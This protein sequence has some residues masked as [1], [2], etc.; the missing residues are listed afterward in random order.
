MEEK[1]EGRKILNVKCKKEILVVCDCCTEM[2]DHMVQ[3]ISK[4]RALADESGHLVCVLYIG[5][6]R[7]NTIKEISESGADFLIYGTGS[8]YVE[9]WQ[10]SD[11]ITYFIKEKK[12]ELVLFQASNFGKDIAAIISTRFEAGLT[13][14]C[15]EILYDSE[16]GFRF[17]RAAICDSVIAQISCINCDINMG[18]VKE[19]VFE[20]SKIERKS[21]MQVLD[22]KL[23][24]YGNGYN[25]NQLCLDIQQAEQIENKININE[26]ATVF[27]IGR[28]ASSPEC[29]KAIYSLAE[30]YNACV[31][32]TR[33][34][35][36]DGIMEKERQVGQSGK[37]ISPQLYIGFG[38]FGAS[39]HLVGI[40]NAK[41]IIA[42]NKDPGAP[43]FDYA[44]Y[45]IVADVKEI[46]N[47]LHK[48]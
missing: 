18:T 27:C 47:E 48:M 12:P 1:L 45:S 6:M 11:I 22:F 46:L 41:N 38:V 29:V 21:E 24:D 3:I 26:Y 33:P 31:V 42:I 19:G 44:N 39:Q 30:K 8:K 23:E 7:E 28:G 20:I 40:R 2:N 43:I 15:I 4:A 10:Y 16:E 5:D 35:I 17:V 14:D 36:E 34:I 9:V 13:A 37:S 25:K 32:G